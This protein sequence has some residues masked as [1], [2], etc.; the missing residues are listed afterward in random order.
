MSRWW[1]RLLGDRDRLGWWTLPVFALVGLAGAVL[2]GALTSVYYAQQVDALE[3]ETRDARQNAERAAQEVLD[4]RDE[5]LSEIEEQVDRVR[6]SLSGEMPFEDVTAN[7]V[8]LVRAFVGAGAAAAPAGEDDGTAAVVQE[9]TSPPAEQRSPAPSPSPTVAPPAP[10]P[11]PQIRERVGTGFAVAVEDG[12]AFF[13]TTFSVVADEQAPGGVVQRLEVESTGGRV[14]AEVHS[15]DAGR[16]LALV[17]AAVG[18]LPIIPWRRSD[19]PLSPGARVVVAGLTPS[20]DGVQLEGTVAVADIGVLVTDLPAFGYLQGAPIVDGQGLVV[21]IFST[22]Y[23]PFGASAGERQGSI[24]V[25][26][27]CERMLRSCESLEADPTE[28]PS[29]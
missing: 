29:G 26:L 15:W 23:R 10:Q 1:A 21:G 16:D 6:D 20:L 9:Q 2:A 11:S 13:A 12:V 22:E 24:P 28:E 5:A 25:Q 14:Q 19:A 7:G 27:L 3:S 4:S 18:D 17:R 8:V